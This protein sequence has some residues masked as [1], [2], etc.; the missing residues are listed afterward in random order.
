MISDTAMVAI[1]HNHELAEEAVKKLQQGGFGT[2]KLSTAGKDNRTDE[3]AM[4]QYRV[5]DHTKNQGGVLQMLFGEAFG[6]LS[7]H[8]F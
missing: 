8:C 4:G 7:R 6:Y 3:R 5:D 1:Y 2:T